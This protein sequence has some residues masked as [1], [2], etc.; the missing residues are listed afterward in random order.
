MYYEGRLL[1]YFIKYA[2]SGALGFL[3]SGNK[4]M[5]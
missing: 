1:A 5:I 3:Y 2:N 4:N